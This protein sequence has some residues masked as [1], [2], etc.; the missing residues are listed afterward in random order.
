MVQPGWQFWIDRGGTFTDIVARSPEGVLSSHKLL[1]ENPGRYRDAAIAGIRQVL[2]VAN[3]EAIPAG[4]VDAVKMGTTVA[5]NALLERKGERTLL[6]VNR[7]FADALAIGNQAR[8][9][10]FDIKIVR[11]RLLHERVAEIGGR[12]A[13]DGTEIEALDEDAARAALADARSAGITACAI[14]L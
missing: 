2:G 5:T 14:A 8:P 10:L 4:A 12:F 7:G 3:G 13:A 1:S 6:L 11:P 9:R